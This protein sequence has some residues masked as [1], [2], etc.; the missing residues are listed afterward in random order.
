MPISIWPDRISFAIWLTAVKPDE[1]C[2][3]TVLIA[4]VLGIPA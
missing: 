4:V 1:H 2:L 3:L